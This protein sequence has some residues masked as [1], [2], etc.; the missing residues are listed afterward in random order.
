M[1]FI[2]ACRRQDTPYTP[3]WLM[4]QAGRYMS[5]YR[6][7]R[8]ETGSFL[9]LCENPDLVK[10][11]TLQPIEAFDFDAA[12]IF[13]DI[14]LV[15]REMGLPLDFVEGDGPVFAKTITDYQSVCTLKKD[16]FLRMEYVFDGIS[17]TRAALPKEKALIGFCGSP[18]TLAT[19]MI[20]G[21]GTKNFAK[22]KK[23]LYESPQTMHFLLKQ[24]T[25]ELKGFIEGQIKAGAD[26]I[27]IFDSWAGALEMDAFYEFSFGYVKDILK[28]ARNTANVPLIVYPRGIGAFIDK[29]D[30]RFDVLGLDQGV[31][32]FA[33]KKSLGSRYVLQGNLEP[34]R[35]YSEDAMEMGVDEIISVMGKKPGHIFNVGMGM[36]PDLP[37]ENVKK[38]VE[39]VRKKTKR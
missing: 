29:I 1:I 36:L 22:S 38:L 19:Y 21:R 25:D 4:R 14:L 34:A 6:A 24:I 37:R 18:W 8:Q 31:P 28:H 7:A 30:G 9:A 12:I 23:I 2:D 5:E 32:L 39:I 27:M 16:T 13:S 35:L 11:V 3:I 33:A 10:K 17:Q 26:A 20:E 15:P